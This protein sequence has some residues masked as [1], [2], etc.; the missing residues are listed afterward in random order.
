M[1]LVDEMQDDELRA[2]YSLVIQAD[3]TLRAVLTKLRP[4]TLDVSGKGLSSEARQLMDVQD[5][6]LRITNALVEIGC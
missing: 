4:L 1:S 3:N 5:L 6:L 2:I